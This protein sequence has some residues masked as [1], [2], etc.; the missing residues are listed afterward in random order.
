MGKYQTC[1]T[2]IF[3]GAA[4]DND[5]GDQ[6]EDVEECQAAAVNNGDETAGRRYRN[7]ALDDSTDAMTPQNTDF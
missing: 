5:N 1:R 4:A 3:V 7:D 6:D 2:T